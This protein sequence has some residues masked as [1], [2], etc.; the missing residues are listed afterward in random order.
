VFVAGAGAKGSL[1]LGGQKLRLSAPGETVSVVLSPSGVGYCIRAARTPAGGGAPQV[2]VYVS[3][4]GGMQPPLVKT[5]P[6]AF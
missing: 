3:T 1:V 6:A 2:V 4:H 5:C